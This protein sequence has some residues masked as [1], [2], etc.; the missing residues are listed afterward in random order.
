MR[1]S[2]CLKENL[3]E[4]DFPKKG[5]NK[6]R[7]DCK[8]CFRKSQRLRYDNNKEYKEACLSR[9][10]KRTYDFHIN[11][12]NYFRTHPCVDCGESNIL[13]LE[14]DHVV[15]KS[16]TVS[17]MTKFAWSAVLKEIEKC[18]VRCGSCHRVMTH[19]RRNSLRYRLYNGDE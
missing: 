6:Y 14:F 18:E 19:K 2:V 3:E 15:P 12:Y 13:K 4:T 17:Q 1:C 9:S 5:N 10:K 11:V 7:K 16:F 8:E